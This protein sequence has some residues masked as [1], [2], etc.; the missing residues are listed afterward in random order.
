MALIVLIMTILAQAFAETSNVFREA[1]AIG[2]LQE[3]LRTA[4]VSLRDDL[5]QRHFDGSQRLGSSFLD[6][7]RP[8]AGFLRIQASPPLFE[9]VDADGIP[10]SR[11][12]DH[13]LHL[14]VKN[15][16]A[17]R[18]AYQT[19]DVPGVPLNAFGL[20]PCRHL[21]NNPEAPSNYREPFA[22]VSQWAEVMWFLT[23]MVD[24]ATGQVMTAG[25][26]PII[27][28]T[29]HRR[30]RLLVDGT[31]ARALNALNSADRVPSQFLGRF[32]H[33]ACKPDA[34]P[35]QSGYLY[36]CTPTDAAAAEGRS[37]VDFTGGASL[38]HAVG[39]P[40]PPLHPATM[41]P[42]VEPE[43]PIRFGDDRVIS[44]V[45]SF[46]IKVFLPGAPFAQPLPPA[47]G[48]YDTENWPIDDPE[49]TPN[50]TQTLTLKGV[51]ITLRVWDYRTEQTR[52]ITLIQD[53]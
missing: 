45:V 6:R 48:V 3:K 28:W 43:W 17:R 9:G 26:G 14:S 42:F 46:E 21:W 47:P 8:T 29:L 18:T 4:V 51:Q 2:D 44:D 24:P 22:Y 30:Q 33:I 7:S 49:V 15:V 36:F 39:T 12:T 20:Q 10:S 11:A 35:G 32:A 53:L 40:Y 41:L 19:G 34:R 16:G 1:K 37:M 50:G 31:A 25:G 52:Q 27:L 38:P 5:I 23:P 13:L